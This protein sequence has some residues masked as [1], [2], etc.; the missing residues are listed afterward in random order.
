MI[1]T[2]VG[3]IIAFSIFALPRT[4]QG[5]AFINTISIYAGKS[6]NTSDSN[7][8]IIRNANIVLTMITIYA[9]TRFRLLDFNTESIIAF[10]PIFTSNTQAWINL[11]TLL[12]QTFFIR[13]TFFRDWT[14]RLIVHIDHIWS[15]TCFTD[16]LEIFLITIVVNSTIGRCWREVR[17]IPWAFLL[18]RSIKITI[19][20]F[21]SWGSLIAKIVIFHE[22]NTIF[23]CLKW[24]ITLD[25]M[26]CLRSTFIVVANFHVFALIIGHTLWFDFTFDTS[27]PCR[28]LLTFISSLAFDLGT[29]CNC[30]TITINT[31]GSWST[32]HTLAIAFTIIVPNIIFSISTNLACICITSPDSIQP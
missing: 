19:V 15:F 5:W 29:S 1:R 11:N 12:I 31:C 13:T 24:I 3:W 25:I 22:A 16:I 14:T 8:R 30:N 28:S 2:S 27:C 6:G 18:C 4:F 21:N 20:P 26:A 23:T 17:G 7:T 10:F 32:I 9:I